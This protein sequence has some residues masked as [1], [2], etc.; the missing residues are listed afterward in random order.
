VKPS[1]QEI[2]DSI[3]TLVE[4]TVADWGLDVQVTPSTLLIQELGLT[5]MD[6]IDLLAAIDIRFNCRLPYEALVRDANGYRQELSVA[7][8]CEFVSRNFGVVRS[9]TPAL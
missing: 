1:E 5:S 7:E 8:I 2:L 4:G 9:A 3:R 6:M